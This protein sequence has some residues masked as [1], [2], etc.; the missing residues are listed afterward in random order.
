MVIPVN[1]SVTFVTLFSFTYAFTY[2]LPVLLRYIISISAD[3]FQDSRRFPWSMW[4]TCGLVLSLTDEGTWVSCSRFHHWGFPRGLVVGDLALLLL[5]LR[6]S[7][8]PKNFC[9]PRSWPK[10]KK[11][12]T[13]GKWDSCDLN[14]GLPD[15]SLLHYTGCPWE[16]I[17]Y[18]L[19]IPNPPFHLPRVEEGPSQS[20]VPK[21]HQSSPQS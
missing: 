6:F 9:V 16:G 17:R 15:S 13:T 2:L 8:W 5:C 18:F 7:P 12:S 21:Y 20:V 1:S 10:K 4:L 19:T 11:D 3:S 14:P